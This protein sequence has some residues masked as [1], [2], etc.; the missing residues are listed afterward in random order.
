ML[1]KPH[2][3]FFLL[4]SCALSTLVFAQPAA[5]KS[6]SAFERTSR[7]L[8]RIRHNPLALHVFLE[9]MPKGA[10]L[11]THLEGAVYAETFIRDAAEDNLCVDKSTL[12]IVPN[13]GTTRSLPPQPVCGENAV[14][15]SSAF[16][17]QSFYD[18][19]VDAFS[20]RSFVASAG[21]SGHDH[22]FGAFPL[23]ETIDAGKHL[24]EWV[25]EVA[26]R[27]AAQNEQYLEIMH[28]PDFAL[29]AKLGREVG[30]SGNLAATR[31]TLLAKGL[32]RN[33]EIDREEFA[34]GEATRRR[35]ERCSESSPAAACE[36]QVRFLFQVLRGFP[37]E[38]VFAQALLGFEV[39]SADPQVTGINLVMPEDWY[40]PM[41]EYHRQMQMFDYLHSVYPKVHISLHAGELAPGLV[42]PAGLKFHIRE[43]VQLGHAERIGHGADIMYER[44]PQ[45]LLKEMAARH[46]M[47]EINLTSNDLILGIKGKYSP[48]PI[49]RAAHVP[50]ALSTDDEGVSRIDLTHEFERAVEEF[51][52]TYADLKD[53]ARASIAY[54]FLPQAEKEHEQSRL[55]ASFRAFEASIR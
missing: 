36:V 41:T 16:E 34:V 55:D 45:Q 51:A 1:V 42:P 30:W 2:A 20:M 53:L 27:A 26:S 52:L 47:V 46:I 25:D 39:A 17:N 23:F 15:A 37:P 28:T 29:A 54:S 32:R 13:K 43:A 40:L 6:S 35:L 14:A 44:D 11:H 5:I 50:I 21:V 18:S 48:L 8:E 33:V 9:S 12:G 4:V 3:F 49:Y 19:L 22:F 7:A 10:D 24:G 31:E 38:Q